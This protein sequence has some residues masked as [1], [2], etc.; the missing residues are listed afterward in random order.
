MMTSLIKPILIF[1]DKSMLITSLIGHDKDDIIIHAHN[2]LTGQTKHDDLIRQAHYD[3]IKQ[4][5]DDLIRRFHY[6]LIGSVQ[7]IFT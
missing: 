1:L 7:F 5:P 2:D 3:L 4:A 6:G